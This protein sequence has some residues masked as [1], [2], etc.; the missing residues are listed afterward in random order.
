MSA[1]FHWL[2]LL[3]LGL[4]LALIVGVYIAVLRR[5]AEIHA[6]AEKLARE[7]EIGRAHV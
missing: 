6:L 7:S 1:S 4:V 3:L 5:T 2:V